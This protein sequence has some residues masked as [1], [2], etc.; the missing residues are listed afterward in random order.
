MKLFQLHCSDMSFYIG[1]MEGLCPGKKKQESH[2][3]K[4]I[5]S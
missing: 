5:N 3:K 4:F 1:L 2:L